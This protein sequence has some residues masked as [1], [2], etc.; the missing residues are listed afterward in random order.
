MVTYTCDRCGEI[1]GEN[2]NP[3]SH[4]KAP[5]GNTDLDKNGVSL[6]LPSRIDN[7]LEFR[8]NELCI[9]HAPSLYR[10]G[11]HKREFE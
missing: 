7:G 9:G 3:F 1:I 10:I 6:I 2:V 4:P 5:V 11:W 8:Q